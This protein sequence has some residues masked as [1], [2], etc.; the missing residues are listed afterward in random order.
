MDDWINDLRTIA[1][2]SLTIVMIGNKCDLEDQ[3]EVSTEQ[4]EEK[5]KSQNMAFMETSSFSGENIDK[6]FGELNNVIYKKYY[7]E[8]T[9]N[10]NIDIIG[11]SEDINLE[12]IKLD[13]TDKKNVA[14]NNKYYL[15][16]LNITWYYNL[17]RI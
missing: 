14:K 8:K 10:N 1:D 7:E 2:K 13:N 11:K 15:L 16:I 17:V 12:K 5:A 4:G 9:T 3:R 6:A